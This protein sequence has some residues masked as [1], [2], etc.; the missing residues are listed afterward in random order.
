MILWKR[1]RGQAVGRFSDRL[2][3][4]HNSGIAGLH[5]KTG[6]NCSCAGSNSH[7]K[8]ALFDVETVHCVSL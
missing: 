5:G 2:A 8:A 1:H 6:E 3:N 4:G 7:R